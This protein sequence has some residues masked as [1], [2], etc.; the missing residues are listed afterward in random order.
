MNAVAKHGTM[1]DVADRSRWKP[2]KDVLEVYVWN[3]RAAGP[4]QNGE[5]VRGRSPAFLMCDERKIE[6]HRC[7]PPS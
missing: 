5:Y 4:P 7:I 3:G 1:V 2:G 6:R